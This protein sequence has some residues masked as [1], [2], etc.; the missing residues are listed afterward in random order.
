MYIEPPFP[1]DRRRPASRREASA[2]V[3]PASVLLDAPDAAQ[4]AR[5]LA[6]K[7]GADALLLARGRA[8]RAVEIGDALALEAW[9]L[10]IAA[11]ATALQPAA[12]A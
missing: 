12:D 3:E 2:P 6:E 1:G 7:Y 4:M 5:D 9:R 11:L 8:E 10:V